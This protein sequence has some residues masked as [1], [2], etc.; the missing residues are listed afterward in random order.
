MQLS[1]PGEVE[2]AMW[3]SQL[4]RLA[5]D[6]V[7]STWVSCDALPM[8]TSFF[9]CGFQISE[10]HCVNVLTV[11]ELLFVG[12]MGAWNKNANEQQG[13]GGVVQME[14]AL[15]RVAY[16]GNSPLLVPLVLGAL[17]EDY[18]SYALSSHWD[19]CNFCQSHGVIKE[20]L[21]QIDFQICGKCSETHP[22]SQA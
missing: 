6:R 22:K 21:R 18:I 8:V 20:S 3:H 17:F 4:T 1:Y 12:T 16:V 7:H 19:T 9:A 13:C 15:G 2:Q 5:W 11:R 14:L 10:N